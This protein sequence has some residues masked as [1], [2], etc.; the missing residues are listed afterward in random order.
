[1]E[2]RPNGHVPAV[3][4]DALL[5]VAVALVL[6]LVMASDQGGKQRPDL[7][8]YGFA[9]GF[10]ALMLARRRFPRAV[11]TATALALFTYYGL[12][13]PAIGLAVPVV[14]ALYSAAEAGRVWA[15]VV[16]GVILVLVSTY[17]RLRQGES[18]RY[19][20]GYELISTVAL[21][22]AAVLLGE[23]VRTARLE[24]EREAERRVREERVRLARDLHDAVGH[25]IAIISLHADVAREAL[26]PGNE[27]TGASL[28]RIKQAAT[29]AMRE[30]RATVRLLRDTGG[31]ERDVQS[32]A[33]LDALLDDARASG[34]TAEAQVEADD[35]PVAVDATAFRIVQEAVTNVI[36][37]S[38]ATGIWVT[39]RRHTDRLEVTVV[40]DGTA[41]PPGPEGAGIR[42]MKERAGLVEGEVLAGPRRAGG[43][44]VR[45]TLPLGDV[46]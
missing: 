44:E 6:A 16:T 43:F 17:F 32:V 8:A 46:S 33:R 26:A 14:A 19:L 10:G 5:G 22:A 42:G 24:R 37:H 9:L 38:R 18:A 13:Y 45:A 11:L 12:G 25:S 30:L 27:E 41:G 35:L 39:V 1:M 7:V 2:T 40:D 15:C 29:R 23:R 31:P 3:V 36:K 4:I 34:L 21:M 28:V 20:L